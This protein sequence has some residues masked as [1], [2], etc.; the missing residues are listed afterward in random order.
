M[1]GVAY[2]LIL[3]IAFFVGLQVWSHRVKQ[4]N[5]F[6]QNACLLEFL[7]LSYLPICPNLSLYLSVS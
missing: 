7:S 5:F 4:V 2:V 1:G 6:N 3:A